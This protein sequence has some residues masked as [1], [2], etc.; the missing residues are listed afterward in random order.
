MACRG[1][2]N[3]GRPKKAASPKHDGHPGSVYHEIMRAIA[4]SI[5]LLIIG[6][7]AGCGVEPGAPLPAP[8]R[9]VCLDFSETKFP[10]EWRR[11]IYLKMVDDFTPH[12][13]RITFHELDR[14]DYRIDFVG[15]ESTLWGFAYTGDRRAEVFID[16]ILRDAHGLTESA[17]L[18]GVANAAAHELGHL[19]GKDHVDDLADVMSVPESASVRFFDDLQFKP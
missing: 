5:C 10:E 19:L 12:G 16:T 11:A 3:I 1:G 17:Y 6:I 13:Y 15:G 9:F 4:R 8:I 14:C 2:E 18:Q 7:P